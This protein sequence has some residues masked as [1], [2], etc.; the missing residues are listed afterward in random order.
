MNQKN[1][2]IGL[3][4]GSGAVRGYAII[5][6]IQ[7]IRKENIEIKAVSG[8]SVGAL[9]GAY[10]ALHKEIDSLFQIATEMKRKDYLKLADPNK[11]NLSLI[12][13]EKIK[14]FLKDKFYGD[15]TFDD[16]QI[17][18]VVCATDPIHRKSVYIDKGSVSEAVMAS[19]S[20]PGIFPP[21]K[22]KDRLYIDGGVLD[23]VPI[24]PL[25]DMKIKKIVGVNLMGYVEK[26]PDKEMDLVSTLLNTSYM[27]MEQISKREENQNV[28]ILD[29][30]FKPDPPNMLNFYKWKDKH[31]IGEELIAEKISSLKAWLEK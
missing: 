8:S 25:L 9:M 11:P 26:N 14:K 30:K 19:I 3:A 2:T 6:I 7:R 22:I 16:T 15:A 13:G 18:L 28:F 27:M 12:K 10:Y 31:Q 20:I 21:Y 1:K 17:P 24:Q 23:P 29:P 5:P 4:L